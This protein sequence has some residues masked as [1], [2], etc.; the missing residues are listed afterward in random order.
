MHTSET[1]PDW[2]EGVTVSRIRIAKPTDNWD[3]VL[4]F[5]KNG[6]GLRQL[7]SFEDHDGYDGVMLGLPDESVHL[8]IIRH[9]NGLAAP[10]PTRDNL[11][12]FYFSNHDDIEKLSAR[13]NR[14][15]YNPVQPANPYWAGRA[16]CFE[17]PD[18]WG[19]VLCQ[20]T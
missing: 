14:H 11:I 10:A 19:L 17:D 12:V 6:V 9:K 20:N 15:G 5:Y 1:N 2:P 3:A 16:V 13:L 7:S 4:D 8:E 18:G